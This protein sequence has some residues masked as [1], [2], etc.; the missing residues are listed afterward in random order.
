MRISRGKSAVLLGGAFDSQ[1]VS[2]G[3]KQDVVMVARVAEMP[4]SFDPEPWKL[5]PVQ[6]ER[7]V[8]VSPRV[9]VHEREV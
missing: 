5:H 2:V 4:R 7:Y 9:F 3:A 8:R 6:R 1:N